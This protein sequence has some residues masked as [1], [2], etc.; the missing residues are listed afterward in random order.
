MDPEVEGWSEAYSQAADFVSQLTLLEK[1]NLTT[2][3]GYV[4]AIPSAASNDTPN[5]FAVAGCPTVA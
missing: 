4:P 2:G 1:V 3:T 5:P